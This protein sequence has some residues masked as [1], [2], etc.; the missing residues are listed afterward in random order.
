MHG[1][2]HL[3]PVIDLLQPFVEAPKQNFLLRFRKFGQSVPKMKRVI[4]KPAQL[5]KLLAQRGDELV[6]RNP[7]MAM[8]VDMARRAGGKVN[9]QTARMLAY[10]LA[11]LD[12]ATEE[13]E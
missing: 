8:A 9:S 2:T 10:Q 1:V 12:R 13:Q 11:Q 7:R 4:G 6:R 5:A 3:V